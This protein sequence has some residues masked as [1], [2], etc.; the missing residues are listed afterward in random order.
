M[1]NKTPLMHGLVRLSLLYTL[2]MYIIDVITDNLIG[3]DLIEECHFKYAIAQFCLIWILPGLFSFVI[4][5]KNSYED[6]GYA[7]AF[8]MAILGAIFYVPITIYYNIKDIVMLTDES[9]HAVQ[10]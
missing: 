2:I 8:S 1:A 10:S 4:V 9:L 3:V 5:M 6:Q 7:V